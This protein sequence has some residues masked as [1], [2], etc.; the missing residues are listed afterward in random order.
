MHEG[1]VREPRLVGVKRILLVFS[2]EGDKTLVIL[3][4]FTA[5]ASCIC[6]EIKHIPNVGCPKVLTAEELTYHLLV[7][8]RLI[9]LGIVALLGA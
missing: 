5:L 3:S 2:V 9:L 1:L 7:V 6:T 8:I 4:V